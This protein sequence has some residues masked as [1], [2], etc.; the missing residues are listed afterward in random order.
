MGIF[1]GWFSGGDDD[2][3]DDNGTDDN[4]NPYHGYPDGEAPT[5]EGNYD[6]CKDD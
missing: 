2:D 5:E 6:D 3:D 1:G 4:Y